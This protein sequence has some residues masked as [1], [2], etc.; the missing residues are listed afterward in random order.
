MQYQ[1]RTRERQR[2]EY[3][4][5]VERHRAQ[6]E[7]ISALEARVTALVRVL[8]DAGIAV[9]DVVDQRMGDPDAS[10]GRRLLAELEAYIDEFNSYNQ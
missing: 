8:E 9:P 2:R 1:R 4:E 10:D 3:R 6:I 5:L 7:Q